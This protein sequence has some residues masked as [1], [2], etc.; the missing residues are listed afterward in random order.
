ML[1]IQEGLGLGETGGRVEVH[2]LGTLALLAPRTLLQE[3]VE[4][5]AV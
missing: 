2:L 3:V 5:R 1:E 4:G